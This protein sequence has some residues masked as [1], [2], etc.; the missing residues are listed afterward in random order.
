[1]PVLLV[2]ESPPICQFKAAKEN[3]VDGVEVTVTL[4]KALPLPPPPPPPPPAVFGKPLQEVSAKAATKVMERR[5]LVYFIVVPH[6]DED[7]QPTRF[8]CS[9]GSPA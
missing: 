5:D 4:R 3:V 1:V 7:A 9:S 6:K 8:D 2:K